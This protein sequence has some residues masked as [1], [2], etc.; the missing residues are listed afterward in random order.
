MAASQL[1]PAFRR[2]LDAG[3][4]ARRREL[5]RELLDALLDEE[6]LVATVPEEL[7][8]DIVFGTLWYRLLRADDDPSPR[9]ADDLLAVVT[10]SVRPRANRR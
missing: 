8:V 1:D 9:V 3:F 2:E 5:L 10:G 6:Q 4:L 7:L